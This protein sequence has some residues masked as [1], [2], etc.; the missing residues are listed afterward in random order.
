MQIKLPWPH[1]DLSPNARVHHHALARVNAAYK[2]VCMWECKA[3]RLGPIDADA[4]HISIT[5]CPPDNR[6]RDLDNMLASIKAACD[7]ISAVT[8]VDDSKWSIAIRKGEKGGYVQFDISPRPMATEEQQIAQCK[9]C[10]AIN[11]AKKHNAEMYRRLTALL[12]AAEAS[13]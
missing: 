9:V 7:A 1:K 13:E 12:A 11:H 3:Q 10:K 6:R 8:G 4:L 5:F 2:E